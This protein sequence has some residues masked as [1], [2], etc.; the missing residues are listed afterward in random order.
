[1]QW[2]DSGAP[3]WIENDYEWSSACLQDEEVPYAEG[4]LQQLAAIR[5]LEGQL[6]ALRQGKGK[7]KGKGKTRI[8]KSTH[9]ECDKRVKKPQYLVSL[10]DEVDLDLNVEEDYLKNAENLLEFESST[11]LC[12]D[13]IIS[14]KPSLKLQ[15]SQGI[16]LNSSGYDEFESSYSPRD[17]PATRWFYNKRNLR[18]QICAPFNIFTNHRVNLQK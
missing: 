17:V 16:D 7:G 12:Y 1:M 3:D 8:R 9:P 11:N 13:G 4:Y 15:L 10:I 18:K 14:N 6:D 2:S 5:E